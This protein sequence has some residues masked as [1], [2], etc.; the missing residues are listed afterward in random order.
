MIEIKMFFQV[1]LSSLK[2]MCGKQY[3]S[4]SPVK[5]KAKLQT[6]NRKIAC[7]C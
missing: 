1:A 2:T 4:L 6:N 7:E 3:R 5:G